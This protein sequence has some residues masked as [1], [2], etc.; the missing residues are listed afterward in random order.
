MYLKF[1]RNGLPNQFL[2]FSNS[3]AIQTVK[4]EGQFLGGDIEFE[5]EKLLQ[6]HASL[7][8]TMQLGRLFIQLEDFD[9]INEGDVRQL[10]WLTDCVHVSLNFEVPEARARLSDRNYLICLLDLVALPVLE[11]RNYLFSLH[12]AWI[13]H[14]KNTSYLNWFSDE[15]ELERCDFAWEVLESRLGSNLLNSFQSFPVAGQ[16][17]RK[18]QGDVGLKCYFDFL[19]ISDLEKKFHVDHIRKLWNQRKYRE[20]Q[21]KN[22]VRQRN[23]VLSDTTI[24]NL[25]KLA[26]GLGI[27]RTEALERLIEL[28]TKHGLPSAG[29]I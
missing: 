14:L 19:R 5:L 16:E 13:G 15:D 29:K 22:K 2:H 26:K 24:K 27:S 10:H 8:P 25:D 6:I 12:Q 1:F 21:E 20:R 9:W 17:F 11:K 7:I 4:S 23:F 28:A 18:Y 3:S